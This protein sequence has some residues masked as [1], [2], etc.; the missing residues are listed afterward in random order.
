MTSP[1]YWCSPATTPRPSASGNKIVSAIR[2]RVGTS[3]ASSAMEAACRF[4]FPTPTTLLP[5]V[6]NRG[7]FA[8]RVAGQPLFLQDLNCHCFDPSRTLVLNPAAWSDPAAG[9][10]ASS[11]AYY[12]DYRYQRRPSESMSFGRDF[13]IKER[14]Q[15]QHP[16][17][18]HQYFQPHRDRQSKFNQ[19]HRCHHS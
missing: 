16:C 13:R 14:A 18:I 7:T 2:C 6:L 12:S 17:G 10:F 3:V 8:N 11:T 4:A 19:L 1:S 9:Q 15:P 5:A